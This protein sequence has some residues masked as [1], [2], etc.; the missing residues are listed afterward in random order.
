V[1]ILLWVR[2]EVKKRLARK[3]QHEPV[4]TTPYEELV[5]QQ[6]ASRAFLDSMQQD[7]DDFDVPEEDFN[8][9]PRRYSGR[10]EPI[11]EE[12][13][14]DGYEEDELGYEE[15]ISCGDV[16]VVPPE[17]GHGH[18]HGHDALVE[19]QVAGEAQADDNSWEYVEANEGHSAKRQK[20]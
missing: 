15:N 1:G 20:I 9:P 14:E 3:D 18:G 8:P 13:F 12:H 11:P 2:K 17:D 4:N 7:D 6:D 5:S 16:E 10:S 19:G